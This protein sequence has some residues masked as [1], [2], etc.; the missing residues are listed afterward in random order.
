MSAAQV[1]LITGAGGFAGVHLLNELAQ[2]TNWE[3]V[4]LSRTGR[5]AHSSATM[6]GCDLQDADLVRRVV[7]R[8]RP[9]VIMHLAAQT[10]VPKSFGSPTATLVNN[11]VSQVNRLSPCEHSNLTR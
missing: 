7:E 1:A 6:L 2:Q 3:L 10:Y 5:P 4:G 11:I 9:N 8:W